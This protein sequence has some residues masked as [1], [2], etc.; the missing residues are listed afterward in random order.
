M[1]EK[2]IRK[3]QKYALTAWA[4]SSLILLV[5]AMVLPNE[6]GKYSW[7]F[8]S[9]ALAG[10]GFIIGCYLVVKVMMGKKK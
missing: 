10:S 4:I 2:N 1:E 6:D 5:L 9:F 8:S 7:I 3:F